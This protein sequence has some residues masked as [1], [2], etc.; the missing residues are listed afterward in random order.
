MEMGKRSRKHSPRGGLDVNQLT[1]RLIARY[2]LKHIGELLPA[3]KEDN[4]DLQ[5]NLEITGYI[6][7]QYYVHLIGGLWRQIDLNQA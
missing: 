1:D 7:Q 5:I 6:A 3:T 2:G 4:L